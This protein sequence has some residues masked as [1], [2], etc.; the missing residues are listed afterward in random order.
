[1]SGYALDERIRCSATLTFLFDVSR[2]LGDVPSRR[3]PVLQAGHSGVL[4]RL[5]EFVEVLVRIAAHVI[6]RESSTLSFSGVERGT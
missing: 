6:S 1:M 5:P 2:D 4:R 3:G